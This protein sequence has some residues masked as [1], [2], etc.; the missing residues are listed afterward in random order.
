MAIEIRAAFKSK[1]LFLNKLLAWILSIAKWPP[2]NKI[3]IAKCASVKNPDFPFGHQ[4]LLSL[5]VKPVK[6]FNNLFTLLRFKNKH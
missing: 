1:V 5:K 4:G 2:L 6:G 3:K